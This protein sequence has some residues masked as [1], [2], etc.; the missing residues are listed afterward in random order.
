MILTNVLTNF[1]HGILPAC[2]SQ[3]Q[4]DFDMDET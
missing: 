2:T 1:D 3:M 4:S